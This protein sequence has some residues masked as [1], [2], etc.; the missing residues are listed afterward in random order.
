MKQRLYLKTNTA[1]LILRRSAACR[2]V[3][4]HELSGADGVKHDLIATVDVDSDG[5]LDAITTEEVNRGVIW[6]ENPSQGQGRAKDQD[7]K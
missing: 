7:Q 1:A 5:D 4:A 2:Q 3:D 6:Y